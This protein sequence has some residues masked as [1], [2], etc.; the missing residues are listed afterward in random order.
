MCVLLDPE[1]LSVF[2]VSS[3]IGFDFFVLSVQNAVYK[4]DSS[5]RERRTLESTCIFMAKED[6]H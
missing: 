5:T 3:I 4:T 6:N 1:E 2:T